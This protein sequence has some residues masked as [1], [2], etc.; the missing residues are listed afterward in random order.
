MRGRR[1]VPPSMSGTP[2][3]RSRQPRR[4]GRS[5]DAEVAPTR[6]LEPAGDAPPLDRG[7]HR[8]GQ[9]EAGRAER[10]ARAQPGEVMQV[11]AG[12][13]RAVVAGE[14]RDLRVRV[15]LE[16]EERVEQPLR[17]LAVDGVAHRGLVDPH[18][19]S[20]IA[21]RRATVPRRCAWWPARRGAVGSRRRPVPTLGRR[22][23]GS[24]GAIFNALHSST[25][26]STGGSPTCSP[27][28][29]RSASRRCP[30]GPRHARSSNETAPRSP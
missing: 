13:E 28:A 16:R 30:A 21:D 18:D 15:G 6:Q 9:L 20:T 12:A 27:A 7:D 24:A 11:G 29:A 23:T 8:L 14:D 3:R 19:R 26:S 5:R 10:A 22:G 1:T 4:G 2:H 17:G 25:R